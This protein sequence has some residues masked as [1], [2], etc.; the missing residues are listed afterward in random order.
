MSLVS[1]L[2]WVGARGIGIISGWLVVQ[3]ESWE[4]LDDVAVWLSGV[5]FILAVHFVGVI[6]MFKDNVLL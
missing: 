1:I 2:C 3:L 4:C 6:D 5:Q